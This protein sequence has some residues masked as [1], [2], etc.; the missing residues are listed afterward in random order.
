MLTMTR[1]REPCPEC[2]GIGNW[3]T[4]APNCATPEMCAGNG[5]YW[6]CAGRWDECEA[7]DGEGYLS[8][9]PAGGQGGGA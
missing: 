9:A 6:S 4:H 2:G 7:C 8:P 3:Y 1:G 5:D